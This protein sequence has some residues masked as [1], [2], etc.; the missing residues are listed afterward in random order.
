LEGGEEQEGF[1][2]ISLRLQILQSLLGTVVK[3]HEAP[4]SRPLP[5]IQHILQQILKMAEGVWTEKTTVD[6]KFRIVDFHY[7]PV[8]LNKDSRTLLKPYFYA[9]MKFLPGRE[10]T[11]IGRHPNM[12]FYLLQSCGANIGS[13]VLTNL[14]S[15]E[16]VEDGVCRL[17]ACEAQVYGGLLH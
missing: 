12:A 3:F 17:L 2:D 7:A 6:I 14:Q 13:V 4:S 15:S 1:R 8:V 11:L 9:T 10:A 16:G 5:A